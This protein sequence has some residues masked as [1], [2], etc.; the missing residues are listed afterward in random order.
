MALSGLEDRSH[1]S[2]KGSPEYENTVNRKENRSGKPH[3][4]ALVKVYSELSTVQWEDS[5][6]LCQRLEANAEI[7]SPRLYP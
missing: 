7:K 2:Q 1:S 4:M 3:P 5:G 6:Q